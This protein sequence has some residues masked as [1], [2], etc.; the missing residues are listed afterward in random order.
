[1]ERGRALG[2]SAHARQDS[3]R[4][5]KALKR[6]TMLAR[7]VGLISNEGRPMFKLKPLGAR[8]NLAHY[9]GCGTCSRPGVWHLL[10]TGGV[11]LQEPQHLATSLSVLRSMLIPQQVVRSKRTA[12][13]WLHR[14]LHARRVCICKVHPVLTQQL[15]V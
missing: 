11:A 12:E 9:R 6:L 4:N 15:N 2:L 13:A 5:Y 14:A 1:M 8:A 10:T 7:T 3:K